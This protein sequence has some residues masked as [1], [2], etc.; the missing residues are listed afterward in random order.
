MMYSHD[1]ISKGISIQHNDLCTHH[2]DVRLAA[3]VCLLSM[4]LSGP[5]D[6][7]AS[8]FLFCPNR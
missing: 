3:V 6:F 8:V 2:K 1:I 4:C 7:T 5:P